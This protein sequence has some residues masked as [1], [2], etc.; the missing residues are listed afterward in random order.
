MRGNEN[1]VHGCAAPCFQSTKVLC[2]ITTGALVVVQRLGRRLRA[3]LAA[4]AILFAVRALR[5]GRR[6]VGVEQRELGRARVAAAPL[7]RAVDE[8]VVVA[9]VVAA[10]AAA[11]V[12][13]AVIAAAVIRLLSSVAVSQWMAT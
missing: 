1:P 2:R 13:V 12:A 5:L 11:A 4:A 3:R 8:Q 7:L 10:A 6:V 9:I